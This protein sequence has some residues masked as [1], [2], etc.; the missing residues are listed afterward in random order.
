MDPTTTPEAEDER[1]RNR[2][3]FAARL[4]GSLILT[5]VIALVVGLAAGF[6]IGFKVEQN[7]VKSDVNRLKDQVASLKKQGSTQ[8]TSKGSNVQLIGQVGAV[9]QGSVTIT[10]ASGKGVKFNATSETV[11]YKTTDG[12]T[13]DIVGGGRIMFRAR[14]VKKNDAFDVNEIIV[15]PAES[16]F[17]RP[18]TAVDRGTVTITNLKGK[19]A[20]I[21]TNNPTV[22]RGSTI[23]TAADITPGA[24]IVFKGERADDG[25]IAAQQ[26]LVLPAGSK[27]DISPPAPSSKR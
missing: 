11:V 12:T 13:A 22:V 4:D 20:K 24:T 17:G 15:L 10:S 14:N 26:I 8:G 5:G 9:G 21:N 18:V 27:F 1:S 16:P 19:P 7:R 3:G 25:T 23:G 6:A 2:K